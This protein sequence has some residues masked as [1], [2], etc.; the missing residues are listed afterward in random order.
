LA[1]KR[2]LNKGQWE[3]RILRS[4][5]ADSEAVDFPGVAQVALLWRQLRQ[6]GA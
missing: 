4:A 5:V 1:G 6:H 3:E 2:E